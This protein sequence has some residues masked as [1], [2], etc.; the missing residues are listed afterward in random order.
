MTAASLIWPRPRTEEMVRVQGAVV[1][2]GSRQQEA[3]ARHQ[4]PAITQYSHISAYTLL[5]R[6]D[7]HDTH[8]RWRKIIFP[9]CCHCSWVT[10]CPPVEI[11]LLNIHQI[12]SFV[13]TQR[14]SVWAG[15]QRPVLGSGVMGGDD[16]M[17]ETMENTIQTQTPRAGI[18]LTS[19]CMLIGNI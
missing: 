8:R 16:T 17:Q 9:C 14:A 1:S 18:M 11:F 3:G 10:I 6:D 7:I 19:H 12:F 5:S 4:Q 15:V 13:A 2:L